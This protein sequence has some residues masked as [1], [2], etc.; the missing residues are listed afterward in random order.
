M[1]RVD[2]QSDDDDEYDPTATSG[3]NHNTAVEVKAATSPQ[4]LAPVETS[5]IVDAP[6]G[7]V[8][9]MGGGVEL[10][11]FT[12]FP[13]Y[14]HA[15]GKAVNSVACDPSGQYLLSGGRDGAIAMW[16][17]KQLLTAEESG[18]AD[19]HR[20]SA[21]ST[22][23][24]GF[25]MEA[26]KAAFRLPFQPTRIIQPFINRMNNSNQAIACLAWSSDSSYFVAC[27]DGECPVTVSKY[28]KVSEP[29]P[30]GQRNLLDV[31]KCVGHKAPVTSCT[32]SPLEVKK[33]ATGSG[34][35]SVRLWDSSNPGKGS[36]SV[37]KH[38]SGKLTEQLQVNGITFLDKS[39][40]LSS[41]SDGTVQLW[42]TSLPYRP[43]A[44]ATTIRLGASG[45]GVVVV[46]RREDHIG[47]R[48]EDGSLRI[49][50]LR[51]VRERK[52]GPNAEMECL[53]RHDGLPYLFDG[54]PLKA[55][56]LPDGS[57][58]LVTVTR[59]LKLGESGTV[60][61]VD[62][63]EALYP[64]VTSQCVAPWTQTHL[65]ALD[66]CGATSQV[67]VGAADGA[68]VSLFRDTS[69]SARGDGVSGSKAAWFSSWRV[70][71]NKT[72]RSE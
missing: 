38:G 16:D 61:H 51:A 8:A 15:H 22:H 2:S 33:L 39:K 63:A 67:V 3:A 46:P 44:A 27:E 34:D 29:F 65:T 19:H 24:S 11:P 50:D 21:A 71:R 32:T 10:W 62:A 5:S 70:H 40:L 36:L 64:I 48:A 47:V 14:T 43:G 25:G 30:R 26:K 52:L 42:D 1:I 12:P 49:Y 23:G 60:V 28:G 72:Q 6:S 69:G 35:G 54:T 37:Y 31:T 68:V 56:E 20:T 53:V 7:F 58:R 57:V 66:V 13:L 4:Q 17:V 18:E 9:P 41:G 55:L 59:S 45:A